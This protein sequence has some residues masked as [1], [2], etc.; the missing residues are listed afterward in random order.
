[1]KSGQWAAIAALALIAILAAG[2][3]WAQSPGGGASGARTGK[4]GP[5]GGGDA[6]DPAQMA[7][8]G[9]IAEQARFQLRELEEDLKLVPAQRSAW[10]AYSD[11]VAKLADDIVRT[12]NAVRFPK[13]TAPEQLEFV[14]ETLRNRL[15][16]V[17]DIADAGKALYATLTAD[18]KVIAD[19]RL[20]RIEI[21]LVTPSQPVADSALRGVRPG[22][23]APQGSAP[24]PR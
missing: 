1:L 19:G 16:A 2:P 12:R 20:A 7:A 18:Q 14:T 22:G 23:D 10:A 11:K 13:G 5:R 15:T 8:Q 3:A 4:G 6:R 21:P 24:P 9:G 17:E